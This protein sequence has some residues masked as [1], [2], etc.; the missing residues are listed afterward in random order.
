MGKNIAKEIRS[1]RKLYLLF[2]L[3]PVVVGIFYLGL[4]FGK[5]QRSDNLTPVEMTEDSSLELSVDEKV[6]RL[7][8]SLPE[9]REWF[10][11]FT[12]ADG[13]SPLTGGKP[14][15]EVGVVDKGVYPVHVYESMEDHNST[16]NWYF[17]NLDTGDIE[18]S[19]GKKYK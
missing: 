8:R 11:L 7:V 1:S 12:N 3:I 13:T 18:D 10:G 9:V 4:F 6:T 14:I 15:I 2:L 19:F 17:V 16:L 5:N